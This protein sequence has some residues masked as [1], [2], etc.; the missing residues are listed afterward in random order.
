MNSKDVDSQS[1]ERAG[2]STG[3]QTPEISVVVTLYNEEENVDSMTRNLIDTFTSQLRNHSFE[4]LL[5]LNGSLDRTP[6]RASALAAEF[7]QIQLIPIAT[8]QGYGGG[9]QAGLKAASGNIIGYTDAD[10]QISAREAA[11]IFAAALEQR[12]DLVK[13]VRTTR[14]D[15]FSRFLITTVYNILFRAVFALTNEDINAKPKVFRRSALERL[16]LEAKDWFIDAEVMIQCQRLSLSIKE[17]PV[18]FAARK[19]GSSN[20]RFSTIWEFLV[21]MWKY[22]NEQR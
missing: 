12:Y 21:N 5:V 9:I 3:E 4:L 14:E 20:V 8:N 15:G 13:A 1:N 11:A 18:S 10:E 17:I 7:P 2:S 6:E 22:R 19:K 16:R